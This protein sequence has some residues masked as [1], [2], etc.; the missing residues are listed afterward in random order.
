MKH[1]IAIPIEKGSLGCQFGLCKNFMIYTIN[2]NGSINSESCFNSNDDIV[3]QLEWLKAH[4]VTDIIAYKINRE[5]I[6][7]IIKNK[8]NIFIGAPLQSPEELLRSYLDG[9][10]ES[11][12]NVLHTKE[13]NNDINN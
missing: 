10:L 7:L 2:D 1:R 3:K 12:I 5:L 11:D 8:M 13:L 9:N 4:N 6:E